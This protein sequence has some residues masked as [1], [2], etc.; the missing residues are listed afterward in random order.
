MSNT[1][2]TWDLNKTINACI[3]AVNMCDSD[4]AFIK[5]FKDTWEDVL[6]DMGHDSAIAFIK[7]DL[8][9]NLKGILELLRAVY[10]NRK[11]SEYIREMLEAV[12][13]QVEELGE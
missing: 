2:I 11:D 13:V 9:S 4:D 10:I 5:Y 12:G 1:I 8:I 6:K 3:D 7:G